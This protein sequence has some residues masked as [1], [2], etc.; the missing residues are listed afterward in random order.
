MRLGPATQA[1]SFVVS[2]VCLPAAR[3]NGTKITGPTALPWSATF[4]EYRPQCV[5][6]RITRCN[7]RSGRQPN[8]LKEREVEEAA[9]P[10][11]PASAHALPNVPWQLTLENC[12][13]LP[14]SPQSSFD[15]LERSHVS[16]NPLSGR[17]SRAATEIS[18][19]CVRKLWTLI[20]PCG[21]LRKSVE[22]IVARAMSASTFPIT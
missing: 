15:R 1:A 16:L 8:P 18:S 6:R 3:S 5:V 13:L 11:Q 10:G 21:R 7:R 20:L 22:E 4:T 17:M 19:G 2:R 14:A 12:Q 9:M